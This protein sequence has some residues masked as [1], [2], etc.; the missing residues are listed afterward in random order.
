MVQLEFNREFV[1][2]L[3]LIEHPSSSVFI[4][5]KAGTGKS[6]LLNYFKTQSKMQVAVLAPTGVA[7][8][9]IR[10]ETIH[11]F[12]RFKP[13][14]NVESAHRKGSKIKKKS[15]YNK[16]EAIIIDEISMVR[17]D[18]LDAVD[19]FLRA[20]RGS[21]RP[22]GGVKMVFIG[23]LYQLPP[24]LVE[25][26]KAFF[27]LFYSSPFFF[28]SEVM[29]RADFELA[30]IELTKI[31]RQNETE[32]ISFLNAVRDNSI[33]LDQLKDM[34]QQ[35][36]NNERFS[37]DGYVYL[38][39]TNKNAALINQEKLR[40][41][42]GR[43]NQFE[44]EIKGDFDLKSVPT[45]SDLVLKIGAQVMFLVND[46]GGRWVNG[47]IGWIQDICLDTIVVDI[48]DGL[49]N[50]TVE[51]HQWDM[52]KYGLGESGEYLVQEKVGSFSQFPLKLAWAITIHKSQ[53]KTFEKVV[54]DL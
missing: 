45:D 35:V 33:S 10:G 1:E 36:M 51:K 2:A 9:N 25:K 43:T 12:F 38:T 30:Y 49:H 52:Y 16:I 53:G 14:V 22:F 19:A 26:E 23:D 27:D 21:A 13:G 18:L 48:Q 8:L 17:A 50:V 29:A 6:T 4:T 54:L 32:F 11:S 20:A 31:Y 34:N 37:D 41:L 28:S 42:D 47:S 46:P 40:L 44:A 5:G 15:K 3:N 39:A 24:V 7:A